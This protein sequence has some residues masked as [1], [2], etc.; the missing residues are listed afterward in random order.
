[1]MILLTSCFFLISVNTIWK[2]RWFLLDFNFWN[3]VCF[4]F[5]SFIFFPN[6]PQTAEDMKCVLVSK[7]SPGKAARWFPYRCQEPILS[8]KRFNFT[9]WT[10]TRTRRPV[11]TASQWD[12]V[13]S[14]SSDVENRAKRCR[15]WTPPVT[16]P[17]E[18]PATWPGRRHPLRGR[19]HLCV[20]KWRS[21]YLQWGRPSTAHDVT[22]GKKSS[23]ASF[24]I[25]WWWQDERTCLSNTVWRRVS[26]LET[27]HQH[28]LEGRATVTLR[29]AAHLQRRLQIPPAHAL[30][31]VRDRALLFQSVN[32]G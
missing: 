23:H 25:T 1:M 16:D 28:W 10:Q 5:W 27:R 19:G 32:E 30:R 7:S 6:T 17:V 24:H 3:L 21:R 2:E 11:F 20:C 4:Q 9:N 13:C 29:A 8:T 22:Y 12:L 31:R 26:S 14:V 18:K 15:T